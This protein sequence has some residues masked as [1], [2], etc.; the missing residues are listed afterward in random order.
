MLCKTPSSS[1]L[2]RAL[3]A[4]AT[5]C[6]ATAAYGTAAGMARMLGVDPGQ[7]AGF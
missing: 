2:L 4:V 6:G 1:H 5:L 7:R 3:L